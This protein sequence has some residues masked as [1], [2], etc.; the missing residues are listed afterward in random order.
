[1]IFDITF[2]LFI[3]NPFN[4]NRFHLLYI[5]GHPTTMYRVIEKIIFNDI[6]FEAKK[7]YFL[8]LILSCSLVVF[9]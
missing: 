9:N 5:S 2:A 7:N 3:L 4:L 6:N 8:E 1:M